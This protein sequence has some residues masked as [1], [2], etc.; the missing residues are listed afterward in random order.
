M[1]EIER[2]TG[3]DL[4]VIGRLRSDSK[5]END[6]VICIFVAYFDALLMLLFFEYLL[7]YANNKAYKKAKKSFIMYHGF[8][9]SASLL[10][11][12]SSIAQLYMVSSTKYF[13]L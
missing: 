3:E 7:L 2:L 4:N 11:M 13:N 8:A 9:A 1:R 10:S 12:V 5:I 6:P